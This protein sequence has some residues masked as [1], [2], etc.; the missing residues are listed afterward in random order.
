MP[1]HISA[2]KT[3]IA[4]L[5]AVGAAVFPNMSAAADIPYVLSGAI[6]IGAAENAVDEMVVGINARVSV[7]DTGAV[8]GTGTLVYLKMTG[9]EWES[10]HPGGSPSPWCRTDGV[11]DGTFTLSGEVLETV[12]RHDEDNSYRDAAFALADAFT[13]ERPGYAPL[14][15]RFQLQPGTLP[16]EQLTF[17][18]FSTGATEYRTTGAA[19][20]GV[21][22]SGIFSKPFEILA[23]S[24][25]AD[26]PGLEGRNIHY[27]KGAYSGGTPVVA[28]GHVALVNADWA[29]V[30]AATN[31]AVYLMHWSEG[32]ADRPL[33]EHEQA[34]IE[35]HNNELAG[36]VSNA[37]Q[38]LND[39][40]S[41]YSKLDLPTP[42]DPGRY[43]P[44]KLTDDTRSN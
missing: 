29:S 40:E 28:E 39:L 33:S 8:T 24:P 1:G 7:S 37:V 19:T 25:G 41:V 13:S 44:I 26:I 21:M 9:C 11:E 4:G 27:L 2:G 5:F 3:L 31:P 12:H 42:P 14:R 32:P 22:S 6:Q 36:D 17:W 23:V 38:A 15:I 43:S 10:P 30:P 35:Q 20:L 34:A 18:G 16:Q